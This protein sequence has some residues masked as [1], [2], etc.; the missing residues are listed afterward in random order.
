MHQVTI[1]ATIT[2]FTPH[3][4]AAIINDASDHLGSTAPEQA[5]FSDFGTSP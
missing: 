5:P 1:H 2:D 3:T 4:V